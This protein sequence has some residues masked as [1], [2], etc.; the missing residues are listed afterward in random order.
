MFSRC[1]SLIFCVAGFFCAQSAQA[2]S[3]LDASTADAAPAYQSSNGNYSRQRVNDGAI[4]VGRQGTAGDFHQAMV[5]PFQLPDFGLVSEPFENAEFSVRLNNK[6][7]S[8]VFNVDL[9]GLPSRTSSAVLPAS[10]GSDPGDFFMGGLLG[11]P[12][13]DNTP[14]VVKIQDNLVVPNTPIGDFVT[15]I[16]VGNIALRNYLNDAYD[17]GAGAGRWVFLR[18]S[19]DALQSTLGRY[20]F[21]TANNTNADFHPRIRYNFE[22]EPLRARPFIWVTDD[23]KQDILDKIIDQPWA[24]SLFDQLVSRRAASIAAHQDD[25]D[26][27]TRGLPVDWDL[28]PAR[29]RTTTTNAG[30]T[31]SQIRGATENRF[32]AAL[33]AA[34]LYYL[35][36]ETQYADLA[37]DIL[38][39]A[40]RTLLVATPSTNADNGGWIIQNDFLLE[41]RAAGN[42]L[43]VIYDLIYDYLVENPV[44]DVQTGGLAT[45]AFADAQS[46]FRQY[47]QLARDRG[48]ASHTNWHALM[49]NSMLTNL[50]AMDDEA[51]R[52]AYLDVYL[53]TGTNRQKSMA[54]DY[55]FYS[56]PGNIWPESLQY[57]NAV[58]TIRT[59]HM[60]LIDR[61]DPS[62]NVFTNYPNF[63]LTLPRISELKYPNGQVIR[64]G[65]GPRSGGSEPFFDYEL[66]YSQ[67]V[68]R[69]DTAL[70]TIMGS[71][72]NAGIEAGLYNRSS[73]PSYS[74]GSRKMETLKL[75][76]GAPEIPEPPMQADA[77]PRTDRLPF[78]GIT[79]QRNPSPLDDPDFGLMGFVGGASHTHSHAGGMNIELYG[80]GHVLGAKGGIGP[81]RSS[82]IHRRYYRTFAGH[83]TIIVNGGS[84]GEGGWQQIGINTVQ[85]VAMEP[86]VTSAAV[87]PN[88]SFS[89][90]SFSDNRGNLSNATQQRTLAIV[91]TSPVSGFYVDLFRS[92][93]PVTNRTAVTL[94]GPVTD[95]YHDYIYRNVG[96]LNPEVLVGGSPAQFTAQPSRF[97]NDIGDTYQQPG[98]RYFENTRVTH[99]ANLP[100]RARFTAN[101]GGEQ[102]CMTLHMPA[103]ANRE[104]ALVESPQIDDAPAPYGTRKSPT[105][106]I[107]QIGEA[108][109][110]PFATVFEPHFDEDGGTVQ[111][112]THLERD[113][114]V[115]GVK[116]ES[117]I[118]GT[119]ATHY[120]I[121]NPAANQTFTDPAT[122]FSFSGRF[123]IAAD[124]GNGFISLYLGQGSSM[125]YRGRSIST[126]NGNNSQ[127]EVRF[128]PGMEPDVTANTTVTFNEPPAPTVSTVADQEM[129]PAQAPLQVAFTVDDASVPV[130]DL[131]VS[132]VSSNPFLFPAENFVVSGTGTER[133]LSI[134]PAPGQFGT[135]T[136][137]ITADNGTAFGGSSFD[138]TVESGAN[139]AGVILSQAEDA[140]VHQENV[141]D[142]QTSNSVGV[143]TYNSTFDRCAVFVFQLPDFGSVENPF[144]EASF[145]FNYSAK[146]NSVRATD[147]YALAVRESPVVLG[148][149]YYGQ[150]PDPDPTPG[151][152]RLQE[153]IFDNSTSLGILST[154]FDAGLALVDHLNAAY[155]SGANAGKHVFL[156]LN[157][158]IPLSGAHRATITMSEGGNEGPP[159]T[160]PRIN[161]TAAVPDAPPTV[162]KPANVIAAVGAT[163]APVS[164]VVSDAVVAP[165]AITLTATSSNQS[166]LADGQIAVSG[167]GEARTLTL[168]PAADILGTTTITLTADNG[169]FTAS[170]TFQLEVT[171]DALQRWRFANFG[172]TAAVGDAA[173]DAD[174]D[175]DG[176]TN[177][178]E[179]ILGTD[180]TDAD[181]A[182][183]LAISRDAQELTL[184]FTAREADDDW[185]DEQTRYYTIE[186]SSDLV[187]WQDLPEAT[188]VIGTGETVSL[189][190]PVGADPV[191][192]RLKVWLE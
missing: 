171:G 130:E 173:P 32:N 174:P 129:T 76:W 33:D 186:Y 97:Q 70:A 51:E 146:L 137:T 147:L 82:D 15:T 65:N 54:Q 67:A 8:P 118:Q 85:N 25:R 144:V 23:D 29:Y 152:V 59:S 100:V 190:L 71:R 179:F 3:F 143:G 78:A 56:Q 17:N 134:T 4:N 153:V 142:G 111:N 128:V 42:Q 73:L 14:G 161:F 49:S 27:F 31:Y 16:S 181:A 68:A 26:A 132:A 53:V 177:A 77:L 48:F 37:G 117:L 94:D 168:T 165:S 44:Y 113:G 106:V 13:N 90:S 176:F 69:G 170:T 160:R 166:L 98:W 183:L 112:V 125:T 138:V 30:S 91:R 104:V 38:H 163:I 187:T 22:E 108:H 192:Y 102:R 5:I 185:Y 126:N 164:V 40:V 157:T 103:V 184:E 124:L 141:V 136:I 105:L 18:L 121:A 135:A 127:A 80:S 139:F 2:E 58:P 66:V 45:F 89:V 120:V 156:R 52:E 169:F 167:D 101:T 159:D 24:A 95:Q 83:N 149:D 9:Y 35:T 119:P 21:A 189:A 182:S 79:I 180:P 74:S 131:V 148:S 110:R 60:V 81:N 188:R 96:N 191:F 75:L 62:R 36:G 63:P 11:A 114:V 84:R 116:V 175:G 162:S 123:G 39:N 133:M 99:P 46:V 154:S 55:S 41:A 72:I 140:A 43:P 150:T 92:N 151:T 155:A 86:A 34:V 87:S 19:G 93:S 61:Y 12:A 88:H 122:G 7:H 109:D 57:A 10:A 107:R 172:T 64:Y 20:S 1:I 6:E 47:Y 145:S 158:R 115:V 178:Q 50:L 28:S